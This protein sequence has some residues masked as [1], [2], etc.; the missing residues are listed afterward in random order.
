MT[1]V[2]GYF[3]K[4]DY[5]YKGSGGNQKFPPRRIPTVGIVQK[6]PPT[7]TQLSHKHHH[8]GGADCPSYGVVSMDT[9]NQTR[10]TPSEGV[11]Q[12]CFSL[13]QYKM[14]NNRLI[15]LIVLLICFRRI[16]RMP[17]KMVA[18]SASIINGGR[19]YYLNRLITY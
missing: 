7:Q 2:D 14:I 9:P 15:N 4:Q 8:H 12:E 11:G 17:S 10:A 1:S 18:E 13:V 19:P 5:P 3:V 16:A 6:V